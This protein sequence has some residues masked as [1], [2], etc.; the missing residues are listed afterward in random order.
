MVLLPGQIKPAVPEIPLSS[1]VVGFDKAK[2]IVLDNVPPT[3]AAVKPCPPGIVPFKHSLYP[4]ATGAEG[5]KFTVTVCVAVAAHPAIS[6]PDT[7]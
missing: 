2:L 7:V 1:S 3:H 4:V 6:E 5:V